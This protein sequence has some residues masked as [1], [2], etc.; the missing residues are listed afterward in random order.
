MD[1]DKDIYQNYLEILRSEL[2]PALGCTEPISIALA[3][4]HARLHLGMFPEKLDIRC[5]GNVVK[6]VKGVVVP[7]SG[8]LKGIA[9]AAVL[10]AVA[11]NPELGLEVLSLVTPEDI[12]TVKNLLAKGRQY[13]TIHL[14]ED[15]DNLYVLVE[16]SAKGRQIGVEISSM[17]TNISK[18]TKDGQP[19]FLKTNTNALEFNGGHLPDKSLLTVRDILMFA[20][21]VRIEDVKD[22][23]MQQI[24]LNSAIADEGLRSRYGNEVGRTLMKDCGDYDVYM[25]AKARSAAGSDARMGGCGL[26]V[27]INS[28]SGNQGMTV[29][30][31]VIEYALELNSSEEELL[32]AL[33][34]ANLISIH[35]KRYIGNL[36]A[37]CG[38]VNAACGAAC[39]IAYLHGKG[40][41]VIADTIINTLCTIGGM[42]CDGAKPSCASKIASAV[43]AAITGYKMAVNGSVFQPGEG[44]AGDN[45]EQ[46]I[47][48]LGRV[49]RVSRE[50]DTEILAIMLASQ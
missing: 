7:N 5:S 50:T 35:Q 18:I 45:V 27:V 28:G 15:C 13:C 24:N 11:G 20:K 16:A 34:V 29:S 40:Y 43:D 3:A 2:V 48:N 39:G 31:P 36:S 14:E 4:S 19:V 46:T 44:L 32:R 8:G 30:L 22:L 38:A 49:G 23:L 25:R 9:A 6:N 42:V 37:Y 21:N 47:K 26:P 33:A 1:M 41:K 12:K 10:G 17:H